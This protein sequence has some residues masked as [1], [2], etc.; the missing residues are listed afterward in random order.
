MLTTMPR[1]TKP[2]GRGRP[3][4]AKPTESIQARVDPALYEALEKLSKRTRRTKNAELILAL[5][6]HLRQA[7]L[8]PPAAPDAAEEGA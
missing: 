7:G 6:E 8:W 4:G 5:E 1:N 2:S 3:K